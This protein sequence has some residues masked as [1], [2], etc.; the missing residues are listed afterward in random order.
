[1]I[2]DNG[3]YSKKHWSSREITV[4]GMTIDEKGRHS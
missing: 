2:E 3:A 4:F 1:V